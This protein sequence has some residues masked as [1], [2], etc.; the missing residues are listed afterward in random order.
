[1]K[2]EELIMLLQDIVEEDADLVRLK[3]FYVKRRKNKLKDIKIIVKYGLENGLFELLYYKKDDKSGIRYP[4]IIENVEESIKIIENNDMW[5]EIDYGLCF[6]DTIKYYWILF[7]PYGPV[8]D[9]AFEGARIPD[10]F[11]QFIID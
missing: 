1:M 7:G 5:N 2:K 9:H 3:I 11:T 10:E 6:A 4:V 8:G